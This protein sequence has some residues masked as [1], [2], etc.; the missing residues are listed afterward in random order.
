MGGHRRELPQ[1]VPDLLTHPGT[2][3]A[4][5]VKLTRAEFWWRLASW[6]S[7]RA[8]D[9]CSLV[10]GGP[11][12]ARGMLP[13]YSLDEWDGFAFETLGVLGREGLALLEPEPPLHPPAPRPAARWIRSR[14][15]SVLLRR[16]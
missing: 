7:L 9:F 12:C 4:T 5:G 2:Q 10:A 15:A 11:D 8:T 16:K 6:L 1:A 13:R 14:L 3:I